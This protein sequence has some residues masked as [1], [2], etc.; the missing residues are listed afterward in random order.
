MK[1]NKTITKRG[2]SSKSEKQTLSPVIIPA[3]TGLLGIAIT[4]FFGFLGIVRP[5]ELTIEATKTAEAHLVAMT[6]SVRAKAPNGTPTPDGKILKID[7]V[8]FRVYAYVIGK[9]IVAPKY[10]SNF[11]VLNKPDAERRYTIE[12]SLPVQRDGW[13]GIEFW[14]TESQNLTEYDYIEL[15]LAVGEPE[16]RCAFYMKDITT[17][18]NPGPFVDLGGAVA[19][20]IKANPKGNNWTYRIPLRTYFK[21]ID[22]RI[23]NAVGCNAWQFEGKHTFTLSDIKFV[24]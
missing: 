2:Q 24:K 16:T 19:S 12:F 1:D 21:E 5:L 3:L 7:S 11:H 14:F 22:L 4:A 13:T 20:D 23:V 10:F 18:T 6:P 17:G 15:E 8:P 9:D